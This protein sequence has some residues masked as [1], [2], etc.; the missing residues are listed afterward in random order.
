MSEQVR[1]D[2]AARAL[3]D[4]RQH[5]QHVIDLAMLPA[6]YWWMVA[7]LVVGLSATVDAARHR[8]VM[9]ALAAVVFALGIVAVTGW[10]VLG[11]WHRAQWRNELLAS[12]PPWPAWWAPR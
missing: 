8:P 4:I 5:Q 11:A 10:V 3:A 6:W 2:E 9:I 12:P 1:P 7:A